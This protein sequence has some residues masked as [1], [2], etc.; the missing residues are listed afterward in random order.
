MLLRSVPGLEG[1]CLQRAA[2]LLPGT[3]CPAEGSLKEGWP[4]DASHQ[5]WDGRRSECTEL[6]PVGFLV[7]VYIGE[8]F[9]EQD[10]ALGWGER[11]P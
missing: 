3:A 10:G 9:E 2:G 6:V 11:V 7:Y 8:A 4:R 5:R 1:G